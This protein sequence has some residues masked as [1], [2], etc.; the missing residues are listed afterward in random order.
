V[1]VAL[2]A[3]VAAVFVPIQSAR[4][5]NGPLS[6]TLNSF[7]R[8]PVTDEVSISITVTWAT[9]DP[10]CN[11]CSIRAFVALEDSAEYGRPAPWQTFT[12]YAPTQAMSQTFLASGQLWPKVV[13]FGATLMTKTPS[14]TSTFETDINPIADSVP[15]AHASLKVNRV[16]RPNGVFT[17]DLTVS[18]SHYRVQDSICPSP[19]ACWYRF[20]ALAPDGTYYQLGQYKVGGPSPN[21]HQFTGSQ[22]FTYLSA[23]TS[24]RALRAVLWGPNGIA[25]G[26]WVFIHDPKPKF[27]LG[28]G[29]PAY[30][31]CSCTQADPVSTSNGEFFLPVTDLSAFGVGPSLAMS[32]T[33][34]SLGA[35]TNGPFG[36]GWAADFAAR[37]NVTLA[38]DSGHP[39]PYV[40]EVVQE[41]GSATPFSEDAGD[42]VA[43]S[44]VRATLSYDDV[45]DRWTFV[46]DHDDAFVFNANGQLIER[47]DLHGNTIEYHYSAG[48][49]SSITATGGR[50]LDL[51][52]SGG[53]VAQVEDS[54]GRTV[55]YGYT[56]G[57]LTSVTDP[58]GAFWAYTYDSSHRMLTLVRPEG[59]TTTNTYDAASRVAT[60]TDPVGRVTSFTYSDFATTTTLPDGSVSI[61]EYSQGRVTS[62]TQAAGTALEAITTFDYDEAGN[63]AT[64]TDPIGNQTQS[65]FDADGNELTTT[66]SLGRTTTRTFDGNGRVTSV[67]D[68]LGRVTVMTYNG[69][70]DL[71]SLTSPGGHE[72]TWD[73]N[74]DGTIDSHT[75]A[76]NQTT[77]Y[78]Y[79]GAGRPVCSTDAD[80]RETCVSYD[81]RGFVTSSTDGAGAN[82]EYTYDDLGRTLTVSDPLDAVTTT[83]YD[84]NGNAL[85]IEDPNGNVTTHTYD[86][87]DQLVSSEVPTGGTTFYTYAPRGQVATVTNPN[88][89]VVTSTYDAL[90]RLAT[91]TDGEARTTT[92]GYDLV[93]RLLTT[94]LP[95]SAVTANTYDD[96]GQLVATTNALGKI[97]TFAYDD[98]GQLMSVT[99]PLNRTT[100]T[101][102][103]DDGLVDTVTYPDASTEIH[104]YNAT[105]QETSF[106]N[107][108]GAVSTYAYTDA[109][110]L[111]SKEEPGGLETSYTYDQA[112]RLLG[113]TTPDGHTSTRSYD[114]AGHLT[115]IDYQGTADDVE[116]TYDDNGRRLTMDDATGLTTYTY[117][118]DGQLES[119]ENGNGK[120]LAYEY[121]DAGQLSTITYPGGHDVDYT[122][123]GAGQMASVTGWAT[124]TTSY[125]YSDDGYLETRSDPN[126]ITET[127]TYDSVGQ[128]VG[129]VDATALATLVDYG[130][131]YDD[132][133]Q[134]TST[135]MT[136]ALHAATSQTWGYDSLGQLTTTS[137]PAGAYAATPAGLVTA[138][139]AGDALSYNAAGQLT[140]VVN[141][142]TGV[143]TSYGYDDNGARTSTTIDPP[144]GATTSTTFTYTEAG[145]LETVTSGLN[146]LSYASDG[147]GLRQSR[148]LNSSS[149]QFLWDPNAAVALLLDDDEH[150]Y[151]Y[152]AGITPVAQIDGGGGAEYLYGDNVGSVRTIADDA[153]A[154]V[155]TTDF[156]PFGQVVAVSGA[157]SSELGFTGGWTES[158]VS[159]TYLRARDYDPTSQQFTTLDPAIRVTRSPYSYVDNR[160][161]NNVDPSGMCPYRSPKCL[162]EFIAAM[163]SPSN[164][165][166]FQAAAAGFKDGA[167]FG[168]TELGRPEC[169]QNAYELQS[170]YHVEKVIGTIVMTAATYGTG[171]TLSAS[172]KS[173]ATIAKAFTG[174]EVVGTSSGVR[175]A[176]AAATPAFRADTAHI[177][178]DATGHLAVDSA[179]N[180][181][182]IQSAIGEE[183]LV[184]VTSLRQGGNLAYY[185]RLLPD[186]TQAWAQVRDGL[187]ITNGGVNV[188]PK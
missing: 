4:A 82:T 149:R 165:P 21:Q 153:G 96:A 35:S 56:S 47:A 120:T 90:G 53:R 117:T 170:V 17:Y 54:A 74:P 151:I 76:R 16:S 186:G 137:S 20:E 15:V 75:D 30:A 183:Y 87:A 57:N 9:P 18:G 45:A 127:R 65:T 22:S 63:L 110:L 58:T 139:P 71:T 135:T 13:G 111:D 168:L 184:S 100:S 136:D 43:D 179:A 150:T 32:R 176:T 128:L 126:G 3:V 95:S 124:G 52:W 73:V 138:N 79:D 101:S 125:T 187:T 67:E 158:L 14:G 11:P 118:D 174:L 157:S 180:R 70:G 146:N 42:Y 147:D 123:N 25:R 23:F 88:D 84:S 59:G 114:A 163:T 144:A 152:G 55:S 121:D 172:L 34:S 8:N 106:T 188:I 48:Q 107:A 115:G 89:D 105:G 92:Y 40:V 78:T 1:V 154:V 122:Y 83:V 36:Y 10:A 19:L 77:S 81:S 85:T 5:D 162:A 108:D 61:E 116:F 171:A 69:F 141:S 130:Y 166:M 142:G 38:G 99:D 31:G 102:Y 104:T 49:L 169:L 175:I 93:G 182:V 51:T 134:L 167:T 145:A 6:L 26:E 132:A 109:G 37:L 185:T 155:S 140:T 160:P 41:N 50:E 62:Q 178:R 143:E 27:L 148:T 173:G 60:Q 133:G 159:L 156:D 91:V 46:R 7:S 177:F 86:D 161:L 103:T 119:V 97:T 131:G 68:P 39:L 113:V 33:Y 28:G 181:A 64:L 44:G 112:A 2:I 129:I 80:G 164:Q 29:N 94:T 12:A 98:A 24:V 72:Q 66:D